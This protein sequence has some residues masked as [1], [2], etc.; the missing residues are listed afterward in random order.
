MNVLEEV[1]PVDKAVACPECGGFV[2]FDWGLKLLDAQYHGRT[3]RLANMADSSNVLI[4]A[5]CHHAVVNREGDYY[6]AASFIPKATIETLL[7]EEIGRASC[8]ERV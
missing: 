5:G 3:P 1:L 2:F 4:C 8:R 6:D 7:R